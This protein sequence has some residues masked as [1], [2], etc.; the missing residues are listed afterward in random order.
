MEQKPMPKEIRDDKIIF[1]RILG[2]YEMP[3]SHRWA[4]TTQCWYCQKHIYSLFIFSKSICEKFCHRP[5]LQDRKKYQKKI[6][7]T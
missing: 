2:H 3:H 6:M 1:T 7:S 5:L 4:E